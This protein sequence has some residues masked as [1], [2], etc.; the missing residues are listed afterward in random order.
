MLHSPLTYPALRHTPLQFVTKSGTQR[1]LP[2]CYLIFG[3]TLSDCE[4]DTNVI[5]KELFY[6]RPGFDHPGC[7]EAGNSD[8]RHKRVLLGTPCFFLIKE[9]SCLRLTSVHRPR[10]PQVLYLIDVGHSRD[11]VP[12]GGAYVCQIP[13]PRDGFSYYH[14]PDHFPDRRQL[15]GG[16]GQRPGTL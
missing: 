6:R 16:V 3:S 7:F 5:E 1:Y 10:L 14:S 4:L 2:E 11:P 15:P 9:A 12:D 13:E 8:G